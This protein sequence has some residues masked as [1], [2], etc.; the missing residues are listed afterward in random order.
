L[1]FKK[2]F[3]LHNFQQEWNVVDWLKQVKYSNAISLMNYQ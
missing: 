1:S 3:R 2:Q